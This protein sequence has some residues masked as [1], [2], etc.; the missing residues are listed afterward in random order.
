MIER[1][2]FTVAPA[3]AGRITHTASG[4]VYLER[5]VGVVGREARRIIVSS[6]SETGHPLQEPVRLRH[7]GNPPFRA[8]R[9]AHQEKVA[10]RRLRA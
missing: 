5:G 7:A 10:A 1:M 4:P 2:P 6:P 8:W 3:W 9:K